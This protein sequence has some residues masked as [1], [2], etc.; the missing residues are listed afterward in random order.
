MCSR[1]VESEN[2]D[3]QDCFGL[4]KTEYLSQEDINGRE[5]TWTAGSSMTADTGLAVALGHVVVVLIALI[6]LLF[7][8]LLLGKM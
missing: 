6:H 2:S 1:V 4:D 5:A 8:L 7:F 3:F